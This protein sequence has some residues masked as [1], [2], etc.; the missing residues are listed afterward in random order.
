MTGTVNIKGAKLL[1]GGLQGLDATLYASS[2]TLSIR[3]RSIPSL[4]RNLYVSGTVTGP[5]EIRVCG[6]MTWQAGT[7]TGTGSTEICP[8]GG[9]QI[10]PPGGSVT[11]DRVLVNGGDLNWAAGSV[12]MGSGA[13]V[14]NDGTLH[15]N[16]EAPGL[17]GDGTV[18]IDNR[19]RIVKDTGQGTTSIFIPIDN[20]GRIDRESGTLMVQNK[21]CSHNANTGDDAD[22]ESE[23]PEPNPTDTPPSFGDP[24]QSP[25][26][27][28]EWRGK[29]PEGGDKGSWFN[30][31]T[32]ESWHPDL[33]H[34]EPIGPHWDYTHRG[35]GAWRWGPD[36]EFT[37]KQS[38][39]G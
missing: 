3:D 12:Y 33:G 25:G 20:P 19:G 26:E 37:P 13:L 29:Q 36:G 1:V 38:A 28:W 39:C 24:T 10:N 5:G 17:S 35:E 2:G 15:A 18:M 8:G 7:M 4:V 22:T 6:I 23:A 32:G 11:L 27:D 21:A 14:V 9:G 16:S 34:P 31:E 30:P